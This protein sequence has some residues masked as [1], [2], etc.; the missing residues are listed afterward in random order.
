[1]VARLPFRIGRPKVIGLFQ[2]G[3]RAL[4]WQCN[5]SHRFEPFWRFISPFSLWSVA[6]NVDD[7]D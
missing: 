1:M 5:T 7:D 2:T 3:T 6:E 4:C